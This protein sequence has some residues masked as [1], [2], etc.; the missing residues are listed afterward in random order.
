M[1]VSNFLSK[2]LPGSHPSGGDKKDDDT[3]LEAVRQWKQ[4]FSA[5][6][7]GS[8]RSLY[9]VES[10]NAF[11]SRMVSE[12][13]QLPVENLTTVAEDLTA[14]FQGIVKSND[15]NIRHGLMNALSSNSFPFIQG[16]IDP[17]R[18]KTTDEVVG[19]IWDVIRLT[20]T[21]R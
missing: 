15:Q 11:M 12:M 2:L 5:Q 1:T 3:R 13:R 19:R 20:V 16:I 21:A 18:K 4:E 17:S 6:A 7:V 8:H 9:G 10:E 14:H